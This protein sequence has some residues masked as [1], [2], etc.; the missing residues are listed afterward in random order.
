MLSAALLAAALVAGLAGAWSPCGFSM[1]DTI[2]AGRRAAT[3]AATLAFG[4]GAALGGVA[5]FGGLALAGRALGLGGGIALAVGA[6]LVLAAAAGDAA[7]RRIVPQVRRQ[8]PESWRRILP[9]PVAAGLYGVLL[10]LGFTTFVLSFATYALAAAA[11]VTGDPALGVGIGL[12]FAAGRTLPV[13]LLAPAQE[14]GWGAD[15]AAAMAERPGILRALRALAAAALVLAIAGS[16]PA[17][18]SEVV[19]VDAADPSIAP[20]GALAWES[21]DG[22]GALL[23]GPQ[24]VSLPGGDPAVSD[25]AVAWLETDAVVLARRDNLEPFARLSAPGADAVALSNEW[26]AWR[27]AGTDGIDRLFAVSLQDPAEPPRFV[28]RAR[29]GLGAPSLDGARLLYHLTAA[30]TGSRIVEYDLATSRRRVL[31]RERRALL[32]NPVSRDGV[33]LYV[34]STSRRQELRLDGRV[35]YSTTPT[36]RRDAGVEPGR[37]QHQAGYRN[38]RP[39]QSPRP[40]RGVTVT[41]WTTALS[42]THAYVTRLREGSPPRIIRVPTRS[43][44][45]R[46]R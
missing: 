11:L 29:T 12:A 22:R 8:V 25:F 20:D 44:R 13:V 39:P 32:L 43:G 38:G 5:T 14:T 36:A 18:G 40:A 31:R 17:F 21:G 1:V 34:R 9:M 6:G 46:D 35:V 15:A 42:A 19:A 28:G 10:G 41:L 27:A 30:A 24:V 3:A 45:A 33:V 26:V 37:H 4:F 7:G 23:V 2:A 16:T